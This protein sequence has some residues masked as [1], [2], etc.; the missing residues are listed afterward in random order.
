MSIKK[1]ALDEGK[2]LFETLYE[3]FNGR[4]EDANAANPRMNSAS[5]RR[6]ATIDKQLVQYQA[7]HG[8]CKSISLQVNMKFVALDRRSSMLSVC[9]DFRF[10]LLRNVKKVNWKVEAPWYREVHDGL[11]WFGYCKNRAC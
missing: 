5:L 1:K 7:S 8:Y 10:N 11:N 2:Y 4:D 3:L 9:I 6:A